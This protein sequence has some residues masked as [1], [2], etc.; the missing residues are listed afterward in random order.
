M[1]VQKYQK[2]YE[3]YQQAV[4]R[5]GRNPTFWCSIGVLYYNINQ[6]R[7]ALDAYSRAIKINPFISEVWFDLGSLYESCNNQI[8]DAI[9]AYQRA[10][11][12]DPTN[13]V[14][15][16]RLTLLKHVQATGGAM[17]DAPGPRD[18]HPTAYASTGPPTVIGHP[19]RAMMPTGPSGANGSSGEDLPGITGRQLPA[20][21]HSNI[22]SDSQAQQQTFR[23]PE[24]F[25][26]GDPPPLNLDER[27]M[28]HSHAQLAPMDTRPPTGQGYHEPGATPHRSSSGSQPPAPGSSL[29]LHHPQPQATIT[30][31]S[32][33]GPLPPISR[34]SEPHGRASSTSPRDR[35]NRSGT[36]PT[37]FQQPGTNGNRGPSHP[38]PYSYSDRTAMPGSTPPDRTEPWERRRGRSRDT[39][40]SSH[41][42]PAQA[43]PPHLSHPHGHGSYPP[44]APY[45]SRRR[46]SPSL[47]AVMDVDRRSIDSRSPYPPQQ[48]GYSHS[49]R[50]HGVSLATPQ[51]PPPPTPGRAQEGPHPPRRYDPRFDASEREPPRDPWV[52]S[53]E[54]DREREMERERLREKERVE[55]E[56]ERGRE[57]PIQM[58]RVRE[59]RERDRESEREYPRDHPQTSERGYDAE[60]SHVAP[61]G[62]RTR[63]ELA[64]EPPYRDSESPAPVSKA[65]AEPKEKRKRGAPKEK[66][67]EKEKPAKEKKERRSAKRGRGDAATP[68]TR[69]QSQQPSLSSPL[70]RSPTS[71]TPLSA[72]S[73]A[74]PSP[75]EQTRR[76]V[77]EDYD[78][79]VA[80]A[81]MGLAAYRPPGPAAQ[82]DEAALSARSRSDSD[83]SALTNSAEQSRHTPTVAVSVKSEASSQPSHHDPPSTS[84]FRH[85]ESPP[86]SPRQPSR[87]NT[88]RSPPPRSPSGSG[89]AS[90]KRTRSDSPAHEA[91][92]MFKRSRI[93]ILNP[94]SSPDRLPSEPTKPSS[95]PPKSPTVARYDPTRE[96]SNPSPRAE[97]KADAMAVDPPEGSRSRSPSSSR[98]ADKRSASPPVSLPPITTLSPAPST[99]PT[100]PQHVRSRS[101]SS[102]MAIESKSNS[103]PPS[104]QRYVPL[105]PIPVAAID[106]VATYSREPSPVHASEEDKSFP[107]TPVG[108]A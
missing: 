77:D 84:P 32:N 58:Q 102:D 10:V 91:P 3:A 18:V 4:Y 8:S 61:P 11:D 90:L 35:R 87:I 6:Y 31:I 72:E 24:P 98:P 16:Q 9:D 67:P 42:E 50:Q 78:E 82:R 22:S 38:T 51:F 89:P 107:P 62:R 30:A 103:R 57:G 13:P 48:P 60:H 44:S 100:A 108:A 99:P 56:R 15:T 71:E 95:P 65:A 17:P 14:I 74:E 36:P 81:L 75:A 69:Q 39:S 40:R 96:A 93:E 54:K 55:R 20:P 27:R 37:P 73:R 34:F 80:D 68:N 94:R 105:L 70:K 101:R 23:H 29:L 66:E 45:D 19:P 1:A 52:H 79:G 53:R 106:A 7:D 63:A 88:S 64:P 59:E 76:H 83:G 28:P 21:L 49:E 43:S 97:N 85:R 47:P 92:E 46:L 41:R 2:A 33:M 104:E 26:G 86:H 25:R 12:L 5:D